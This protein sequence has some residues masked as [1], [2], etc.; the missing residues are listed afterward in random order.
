MTDLK[1]KE[2]E[3]AEFAYNVYGSKGVMDAFYLPKLVRCLNLNPSLETLEKLGATKKEGE[4]EIKFEDFLPI[5]SQLKKEKKDQGCYED[6]IE[7]LKLYDKREDGTMLS[8]ELYHSLSSL[9]EKLA[10]EDID[11]LMTDCLDEEND[12][13]EIEYT[14]FLR[15]MCELDPPL[16]PKK[17]AKK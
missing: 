15:R 12:E 11:E 5:F 10:E 16:K 6:F 1:P 2:I 4:K 7:C 17:G 13:G 9:G 8:G 3:D 14:P